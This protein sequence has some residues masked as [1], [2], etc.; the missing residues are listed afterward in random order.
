[1]DENLEYETQ[2]K[3]PKKKKSWFRRLLK[4][5]LVVVLLVVAFFIGRVSYVYSALSGSGL[6]S[7]EDKLEVIQTLVD[8]AFLYDVDKDTLAT[9]V[10]RGYMKGLQDDYA[11][12]YTKEEYDQM[13]EEDSGEYYGIGV[14]LY[15][16]SETNYPCAA[17]VFKDNPA[18]NAGIKN[19]DLFVTIDGENTA[20][21]TLQEFV[22]LVKSS[23][24]E[25]VDF[26]ILRGNETLDITVTKTKIQVA[27]VEW[28]MKDDNIGYISVS[29][30]IETTPDD[31]YEALTSLQ[32]EGMKKL[33]IDLRDNGGGL[34]TSCQAMLSN[35]VEDGELLVY[36]EDKNGSRYEY[37][38]ESDDN[39]I[40]VP[41]VILVNEN[42]A[43][44][45]E[46]MTGCLKDYE[47]ATVV[48]ETTYGKGIVQ[49]II[50]LSDGSAVKFT[51]SKYYTPKGNDIH[52]KGITPDEE[53]V[54]DDDAWAEAM[55]DESKDTQLKKALEIL[56]EE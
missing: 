14:T 32:E 29:Q 47:L 36:T 28:E 18:Y 19:G 27:T 11:A 5:L 48:G 15:T 4:I 52:K 50:P 38:S 56:K 17:E 33:I 55:E 21:M 10:Y 13:M 37:K 41:M 51:I 43:S 31:F 44:A 1:M 40:S 54:L 24:S 49:S 30:F 53:V 25:T 46:I 3:E 16:D 26:T 45:S 20:N 22:S 6:N 42:T 9:E 7:I 35:F 2:E 39:P 23:D 8:Q 34:V 12:Y